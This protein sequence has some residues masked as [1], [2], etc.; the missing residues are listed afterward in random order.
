MKKKALIIF[1]T[2]AFVLLLAIGVSAS[3]IYKDAEGNTLFSYEMDANSIITSYEGEFP[4]VDADGNALTWYVTATATEGGNTVKTVNSILTVGSEYSS[5]TNGEYKYTKST[6]NTKNVVAVY[7]PSNAG[8]TK[9]TLNDGG[10]KNKISYDP[11][12]TEILFVYLPNTLT[13]LPERIVQGSKALVCEMPSDMPITTISRVSFYQAKCLREVN[14]PSTVTEICGTSANDGTA[15]YMCESLERVTFGEN[16]QLETIGTM[17]FYQNYKLYDV[18]LPDSVKTVS[19]W[20]FY[21]TAL[22]ESPFGEGSRCEKLGGRCFSDIS[23]LKTFIVPATLKTVDILGSNDHGPLALSTVESVTF[24]TAAPITELSMGFFSKTVIGKI[25]LPEGPTNIPARYFMGATLTEVIFPSTV[26]TAGERVFQSTKIE[27]IRFGANFKHFI[28]S[29][30]DHHSFTNVT[31]GVKEV[32]LPASFYAEVP[33][34]QYQTSYAFAFGSSGDIKFFYTGTAEQLAKAIENFNTTIAAGTSNWKFRGATIKSYAE[35]VADPESFASGNY[36]FWGYD[37]CA[38]FCTPFYTEDTVRESTIVYESYL[39]GGVKTT[40]CPLCGGYSDGEETPALF[41]CLG[42]SA[43]QYGVGGITLCY[44]INK[45]AIREY[46][47]AT[48]KSITYGIFAASYEKLGENEAV[49]ADGTFADCAIGTE[50]D[51]SITN[52]FEIKIIGFVT[53][54]QM[55]AKLVLSAYVIAAKGEEKAVSYMQ[56]SPQADGT[57]YSYITYND[58]NA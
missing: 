7:F 18:R 24:G 57:R 37:P 17:A 40:L 5:L 6:V 4:K 53:E 49:N 2:V 30:T 56:P 55:S 26:V 50:I 12:G 31:S 36:I 43:P 29:A 16:S 54:A 23:T 25:V 27:I 38:A 28:N 1:L 34:T 11:T 44:T 20:A 15:F 3:T 10:Y 13:T 45:D 39:M 48:G 46:E 51:G 41:G 35:Y 19:A 42:Y 9:L 21:K 14:I 32:Y 47:L 52:V 58:V 33:D 8:I 22:V